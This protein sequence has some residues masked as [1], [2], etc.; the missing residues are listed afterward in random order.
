MPKALKI[1]L[2]IAADNAERDIHDQSHVTLHELLCQPACDAADDD[3]CDPTHS[4]V[5]HRLISSK[6]AHRAP[7]TLRPT[8]ADALIGINAR[9]ARRQTTA[10]RRRCARLP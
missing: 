9:I 2:A 7:G 3:G 10:T 4:I 6:K 8:V 1:A 5:F